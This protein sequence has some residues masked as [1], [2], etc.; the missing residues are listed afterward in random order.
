MCLYLCLNKKSDGSEVTVCVFLDH[1]VI[2]KPLTKT[3]NIHFEK[4][5]ISKLCLV[6]KNVMQTGYVCVCV[7]ARV[8]GANA[9]QMQKRVRRSSS[10]SLHNFLFSFYIEMKLLVITCLSKK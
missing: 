7:R 1:T 6:L 8:L 2:T 3:E 10:T 4:D 9:P 5:T